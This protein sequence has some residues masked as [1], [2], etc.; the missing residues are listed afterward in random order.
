MQERS[1]KLFARIDQKEEG[2]LNIFFKGSKTNGSLKKN[3]R[4]KR[5]RKSQT[6]KKREKGSL[7]LSPLRLFGQVALASAL[8]W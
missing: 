4:I 2:F 5:K 3:K 1:T 7:S 6:E 8:I